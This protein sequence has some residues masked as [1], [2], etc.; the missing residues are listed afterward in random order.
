[1]FCNSR[2]P[3]VEL[4]KVTTPSNLGHLLS[5]CMH[6]EDGKFGLRVTNVRGDKWTS[7]GD[8][9]L[10]HEK[11]KDN[12]KLV[13]EA[14]QLSVD[15]VYEAY[16]NPTKT[17]ETTVVTDLIPF[18]DQEEKI[19]HPLFKVD[20]KLLLCRRFSVNDPHDHRTVTNWWGATTLFQTVDVKKIL[21]SSL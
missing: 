9:I 1:M 8:G 6:D 4:G 20:D 10:L 2:T 16:R 15:Q 7:Y 17:L 12:L 3:R 5:K 11:S 13:I 19:T 21:S 14:V 18:V